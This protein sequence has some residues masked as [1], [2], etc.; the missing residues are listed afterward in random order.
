LLP[1]T[2]LVGHQVSLTV[3]VPCLSENTHS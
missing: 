3:V 1:Q 2:A